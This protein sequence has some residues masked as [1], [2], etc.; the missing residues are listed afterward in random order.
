MRVLYWNG[1]RRRFRA[2]KVTEVDATGAG[3]V[4]AAAFFIRLVQ[5]T[6]SLGSNALCHLAGILFRDPRSGWKEFPRSVKIE[7]CM[8]EVLHKQ[9]RESRLTIP[10]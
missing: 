3:D 2:P 9:V 6:R 7:D 10:E 5:H 1:D 4:F 8:M